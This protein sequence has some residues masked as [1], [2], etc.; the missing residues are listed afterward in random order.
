MF[1][2]GTVPF[3]CRDLLPIGLSCTANGESNSF[4]DGTLFSFWI[5]TDGTEFRDFISDIIIILRK[6]VSFL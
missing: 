2:I 4:F 1:Y 6:H 3:G 5:G